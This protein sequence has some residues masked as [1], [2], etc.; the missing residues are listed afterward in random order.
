MP[1]LFDRIAGLK[2][3]RWFRRLLLLLVLG[4][5][6]ILFWEFRRSLD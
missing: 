4:G 5:L 1:T 2:K 6:A 3:N